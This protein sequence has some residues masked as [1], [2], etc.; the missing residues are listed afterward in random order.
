MYVAYSDWIQEEIE[1]AN[2][3]E[4]PII[5]VIPPEN[6]RMAAVVKE[7]AVELVEADGAEIL[8]AIERHAT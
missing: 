8:D 4:K 7:N 1:I 5:G 2:E 3:M 6:D